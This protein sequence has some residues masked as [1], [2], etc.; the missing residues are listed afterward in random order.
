MKV[1][2]HYLI[3]IIFRYFQIHFSD[4]DNLLKTSKKNANISSINTFF[5]TIAHPSSPMAFLSR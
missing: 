3:S 2:A 4:N 5:D 1:D